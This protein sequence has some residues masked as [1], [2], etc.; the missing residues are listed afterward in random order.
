M[1][2][3]IRASNGIIEYFTATSNTNQTVNLSD[4]A[5]G[6][7]RVL[8]CNYSPDGTGTVPSHPSITGWT[9][10]GVSQPTGAASDSRLSIYYR[11]VQS[12]DTLT[13]ATLA[14]SLSNTATVGSVCYTLEGVDTSGVLDATVPS[15]ITGTGNRQCPS[16]TTVT[17]DALVCHA[18]VQDATSGA[19]VDANIPSGDTL[20]G[21]MNNNPPSNGMNLGASYN[22]Q[23]TA[24]ASGVATWQQS[25]SEEWVGATFAIKPVTE[26]IIGI[27]PP[28]F[29]MHQANILITITGA[30]FGA[31]QGTGTVY[32]S[33]VD[34]IAGYDRLV[35]VGNSITSWSD[36]EIVLNLIFLNDQE[37]N[38][39]QDLGSGTRYTIVS[40]NGAVAEYSELIALHRPKAFIMAPS[41]EF[42]PG[43]TT[44]QLTPP[45]IKVVGDM[46]GGRL[47][48]L[49]NPST[50]LTSVTTDDYREDEWNITRKVYA[51]K[52]A[53][54]FR[55][56]YGGSP[57]G[58]ISQVP[59]LNLTEQSG[60]KVRVV[61]FSLR[62]T[63]G[64]QDIT[65]T[66]LGA[67]S[68]I[69]GAIFVTSGA[70]TLDTVEATARN[71][72]GFTDGTTEVVINRW[73]QDAV[74]ASSTRRNH[75]SGQ[76]LRINDANTPATWASAS[77]NSWITD[78]VRID[79]T[80]SPTAD[81]L[82]GHVILFSDT[83]SDLQVG[84]ISPQMNELLDVD[85]TTL[86]FEPEGV[87]AMS[88]G[89]I[90]FGTATTDRR[91]SFGIAHNTD[92]VNLSPQFSSLVDCDNA[93]NPVVSASYFSNT[94]GGRVLNGAG[95][96]HLA[97]IDDFDASGFT[98][99]PSVAAA[100]TTYYDCFCFTTNGKVPIGLM[101]FTGPVSAAT[102]WQML[103]TS[104][105]PQAVI[106]LQSAVTVEDSLRTTDEIS[107]C[108]Y[109]FDSEGN[110][111]T[112]GIG[113]Q[114]GVTPSNTYSTASSA[115]SVW[116]R[117]DDQTA[118]YHLLGDPTI[119]PG[120][121]EYPAAEITT[122]DATPRYGWVMVFGDVLEPIAGDTDVFASTE[123]LVLTA[124]PA[125]VSLDR[126][127]QAS[128]EELV[129]TAYV[130][131]IT[132]DVEVST[133]VEELTL[134]AYAAT[135][136]LDREVLT[137]AEELVLTAYGATITV[138]RN[139]PANVE[140]LVLTAYPAQITQGL[141]IPTNVE[142]LLLTAYPATISLDREIQ[143]NVE[144][145]V[146]TAYPASVTLNIDIFAST[147]ELVLTT[148]PATIGY[149]KNVLALVEEL[150]LTAYPAS[151]SYGLNIFTA[152]EELLLTPYPAI[153]SLDRNIEA[154]VE[155]L[156]LT[157]YPATITFTI[158]VVAG[159]EELVLTTYPATVG[160]NLDIAAG[161]QELVLTS[162]P[163]TI[164]FD[165]N[166]LAIAE[167]LLLTP[168]PAAVSLGLGIFTSVEELILTAYPAQVGL[169]VNI[170]AS[171]QEL[172]LTPYPA[173]ISIETTIQAS[174]EELILTAYPATVRLDREVI[175]NAEELVLTPYQANVFKGVDIF[176]NT[177]V[178]EL[179]LTTYPALVSLDRN[180]EAG[181][182]E[183]VITTYPATIRY[184]REV[185]ASTEELILEELSATV[186]LFI[187]PDVFEEITFS[188]E[189]TPNPP[190]FSG[191]VKTTHTFQLEIYN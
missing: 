89:G 2:I 168:Y 41:S 83:G 14:I 35:D 90:F 59:A 149:D 86:G 22:I 94:L 152:V 105:T 49:Q 100:S 120:G 114:D 190:V 139:V 109:A 163:A 69:K 81:T 64:T 165:R 171:V 55:V 115:N 191:N 63:T 46:D 52:V 148:Y 44:A 65:L 1:P 129:L 61:P 26:G 174:V 119:I 72:I 116:V 188:L 25:S 76:V 132:L 164:R 130:A 138:D 134:T 98:L 179:L 32:L 144:E 17:D 47:E 180:I 12:G 85:V 28:D 38:A 159:V 29:N 71:S 43:T 183:L 172:V 16:I 162:Y 3:T 158:D 108:F 117:E 91:F 5:V 151:V 7:V 74:V 79:V 166:V 110:Q 97:S 70:E 107:M 51:R 78:G 19:I 82:K 182:E 133:N 142:E 45:G 104:I 169:D 128:A 167:E 80:V 177:N 127:I 118:D 60:I 62:T 101:S 161:V 156:V 160:L 141:N 48:E 75:I 125:T 111:H 122:A 153:V 123:E 155:E 186:T 9:N 173:T 147:E 113:D 57:A 31:A 67:A 185:F 150:V 34:T 96:H 140:E 102:D 189:V 39:L 178:E 175:A 99:I 95:L 23:A 21:T 20:L 87:L 77:F 92:S 33:R 106:G 184:D 53:Y 135:V 146:L 126:N 10:I 124:Y 103:D 56:E 73:M 137:T 187:P 30:G 37:L 176:V 181:V 54:E 6:D 58:T 15:F 170:Q 157:T 84:V 66:G 112:V 42:A 154:G 68:Q 8:V 18:C 24:G 88:Y 93:S 40:T 27:S 121:F 36:T 145:L 136:S 13:S 50:T 143:A 131:T 11:V 4:A